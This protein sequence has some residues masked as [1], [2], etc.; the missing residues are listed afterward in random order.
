MSDPFA[1]ISGVVG[2]V[3]P[4]VFPGV[5]RKGLLVQQEGA[6]GAV[7]RVLL[8]PVDNLGG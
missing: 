5:V 7:H 1:P 2:L 8:H 3:V 6:D 4:S